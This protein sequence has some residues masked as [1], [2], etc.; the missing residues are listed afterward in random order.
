MQCPRCDQELLKTTVK[1]LEIAEC[2]AC[3][4]AWFGDDQLRRLKDRTDPDLSW[5]DFELWEHP[6]RFRVSEKPASCPGCRQPLVGIDY[7]ATAIEVDYCTTCNG[8]WLDPGEFESIIN[9]LTNELL[10]KDLPKY[11]RA[12][13]EEAK[14]VIA[15]PESPLSE[16]RDLLTAM[17]MFQYRVLSENPRISKALADLQAASPFS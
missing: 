5:M 16:W 4:G 3:G 7:D 8:V 10:T 13:L 14:E 9:A 1:E 6:D 15:G 12:S 17:R 2:G 11:V